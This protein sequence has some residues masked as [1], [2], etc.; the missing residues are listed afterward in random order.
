MDKIYKWCFIELAT[1]IR[2]VCMLVRH[3]TG[4][5]PDILKNGSKLDLYLRTK[6]MPI[7]YHDLQS[8]IKSALFGKFVWLWIQY[9]FRCC[10]SHLKLTEM[11]RYV[12]TSPMTFA[13][14]KYGFSSTY[15]K[16]LQIKVQSVTKK[17]KWFWQLYKNHLQS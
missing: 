1:E 13:S 11:Q 8:E 3:W 7:K 2:Q 10:I 17:L 5:Y 6:N 12:T 9:L 16:W 4:I 15:I 14:S